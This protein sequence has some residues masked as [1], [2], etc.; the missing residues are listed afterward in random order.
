M[1]LGQPDGIVRAIRP[2]LQ[3]VQRQAEIVDRRRGRSKWY[4][5]STDSSTKN[6]SMMSACTNLNKSDRMCSMFASDP[7]SML[8]TQ[9]TR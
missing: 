8:S 9:I 5:K 1:Q 6:G 4:A 2:D 7:V 3:R